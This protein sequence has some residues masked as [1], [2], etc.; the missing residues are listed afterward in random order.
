MFIYNQNDRRATFYQK[1]TAEEKDCSQLALS[2]C[3]SRQADGESRSHT[4]KK[5]AQLCTRTDLLQHAAQSTPGGSFAVSGSW[6]SGLAQRL[7]PAL[8]WGKEKKSL[9]QCLGK[10]FRGRNLGWA[11]IAQ[12][13]ATQPSYE[14]SVMQYTMALCVKTTETR[15]I[16]HRHCFCLASFNDIVAAYSY[17]QHPNLTASYSNSGMMQNEVSAATQP[18]C[19]FLL[20]LQQ[21]SSNSSS[22]VYE[23]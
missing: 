17:G 15:D 18:C 12:L 23:K 3:R 9:V 19:Q 10:C 7:P 14:L 16:M 6:S 13:G 11:D 21:F 4:N 20:S 22:N 8:P 5:K 2:Y 1:N